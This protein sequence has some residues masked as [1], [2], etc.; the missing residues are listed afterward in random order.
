VNLSDWI[1]EWDQILSRSDA[2][3][4]RASSARLLA[5]YPD[6]P[7]LLLSRGLSELLASTD[8]PP[9]DTAINEYVLNLESALQS[10]TPNYGVS[11][12]QLRTTISWLLDKTGEANPAVAATTLSVAARYDAAYP[13]DLA[14]LRRNA[15]EEP[16]AAIVHLDATL[17]DLLELTE[18]ITTG[19]NP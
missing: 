15:P 1:R 3:E 16:A 4:W 18:A 6:H 7:G 11:I 8:G 10:A 2:A 5:S 17:A 9:A 13:D 19:D 14:T 12:D